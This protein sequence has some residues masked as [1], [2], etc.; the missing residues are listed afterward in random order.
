MGWGAYDPACAAA[1][2]AEQLSTPDSSNSQPYV[3][4]NNLPCVVSCHS[5]V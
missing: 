3:L 2:H 4:P 1:V 5:V